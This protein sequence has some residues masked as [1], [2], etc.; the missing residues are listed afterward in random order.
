MTNDPSTPSGGGW[1]GQIE[2]TCHCPDPF[3][4]EIAYLA[5]FY[6]GYRFWHFLA[7]IIEF[8]QRGQGFVL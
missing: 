8:K 4:F 1:V 3:P 6:F 5:K 2:M 7:K